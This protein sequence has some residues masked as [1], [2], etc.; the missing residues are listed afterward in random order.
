MVGLLQKITAGAADF[1]LPQGTLICAMEHLRSRLLVSTPSLIY[2]NAGSFAQVTVPQHRM[3]PLKAHW[4]SLYEPV[5]KNLKLDMRMNLK[6][7]K[8]GSSSFFKDMNCLLWLIS[9][10]SV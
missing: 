4:M 3:T 8:V 2:L 10:H 7:K 9:C 1:A 5:T 6:S